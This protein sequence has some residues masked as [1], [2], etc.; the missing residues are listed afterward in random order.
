MR[1]VSAKKM[2]ATGIAF[3]LVLVIN[4]AQSATIAG[5]KCAKLA[6][7]RTVSNIKYTCIKQGSKLVW[8]KGVTLKPAAKPTPSPTVT[9]T[10]T[11]TEKA[12][13]AP[14]QTTIAVSSIGTYGFNGPC[15]FDSGA[16]AQWRELQNYFKSNN[17]CLGPV[18]IAPVSLTKARPVIPDS[19]NSSFLNV[20]S[21]KITAPDNFDI[22]RSWPS[23]Y[24]INTRMALNN[25]HPSPNSVIQVIPFY[26][27]DSGA[28]NNSPS[29]DY[30]MYFDFVKE[31]IDYDSDNGS[32]FEIRVPAQYVKLPKRLSE[33]GVT[34]E[35]GTPD[36]DSKRQIFTN[37]LIQ[38]VDRDINF[39]DVG[40]VLAIAPPG[41]P[42]N[43]SVV[44]S[45]W[46][47]RADGKSFPVG[48]AT[49]YTLTSPMHDNGI[50]Q[51]APSVSPMWW[52]HEWFHMGIGLADHNGNNYWQN[53]FGSDP[54]KP[55]MGNWGLMSM[56]MTDLLGLE[57]W[58]MGYISD[59]QVS[60]ANSNVTKWISPSSVKSTETK[61]LVIP[62]NKNE[63]ILVESKRAAG[64]DFMLNHESEGALVYHLDTSEP[65]R[66]FGLE[67]LTVAGYKVKSSPFVLS[68]AP[69][70]TG[71]HLDFRG[72]RISVVESGEFG[73]VVKV[74]KL[75]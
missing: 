12:T 21:C 46:F 55:G 39:S 4:P 6:T 32:K 41:T 69:L 11:T 10:P 75:S 54:T 9:P 35:G 62:L 38:A 20:D 56:A 40:L 58:F 1:K 64:L 30:K 5:T 36:Q 17:H 73:D 8:N 66:E 13:P 67:V 25:L 48:N 22:L 7:N 50:T 57:K 24:Q 31:V 49:P 2:F 68:D 27:S 59:K 65:D 29:V 3:C 26:T 43:L 14:S 74:E 61:L 60:C 18:R 52:W 19:T 53:H 28:P 45:L 47:T 33:Y 15:D 16:P 63:A 44:T 71:Q 34:H 37:D 70:K 72:F 51:H 42:L 23:T